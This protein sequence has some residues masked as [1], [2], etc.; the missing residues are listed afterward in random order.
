[1]EQA[2]QANPDELVYQPE[3]LRMRGELRFN[4]GENE[5]AEVYFRE[6]L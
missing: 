3:T 5:M 2:L 6:T 4:K 1:V